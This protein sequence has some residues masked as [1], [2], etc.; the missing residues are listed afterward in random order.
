MLVGG[1]SVQA[2]VMSL[3]VREGAVAWS[4]SVT[5]MTRHS[6]ASPSYILA[7]WLFHPPVGYSLIYPTTWISRLKTRLVTVQA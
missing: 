1:G 4:R 6:I 7:V 2:V 3:V 5:M